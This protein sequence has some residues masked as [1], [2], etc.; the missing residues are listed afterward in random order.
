V[1]GERITDIF[2]KLRPHVLVLIAL[3]TVGLSGW[4]AGISP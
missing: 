3:L 4:L 2:K 1:P